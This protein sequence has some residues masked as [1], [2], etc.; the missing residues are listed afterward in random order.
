MDMMGEAVEQRAGEAL[1]AE[2]AGPFVER[3]IGVTIVEPRSWRWLKTSNSNSA[4]VR[5]GCGELFTR[6]CRA[7]F[8]LVLAEKIKVAEAR[9]GGRA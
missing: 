8:T 4:L 2:D 3:Q 1:I 6:Y 9:E 7:T 5:V